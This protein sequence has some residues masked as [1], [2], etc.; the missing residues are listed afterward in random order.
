MFLQ[1]KRNYPSYA[2]LVSVDGKQGEAYSV[3]SSQWQ[4]SF[5]ENMNGMKGN[6]SS[7][8]LYGFV[9]LVT[10]HTA[11]SSQFQAEKF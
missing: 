7:I 11:F 9:V 3:L 4:K 6:I 10:F 1:E 5:Q 8:Q 2:S